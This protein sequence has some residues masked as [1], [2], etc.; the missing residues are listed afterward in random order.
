MKLANF[1]VPV[2]MPVAFFVNGRRFAT[3]SAAEQ[4]ATRHP[5][6]VIYCRRTWKRESHEVQ[7]HRPD[8]PELPF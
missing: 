4:Y 5:G 7:E 6:I 2:H 1:T 3:L 8:R